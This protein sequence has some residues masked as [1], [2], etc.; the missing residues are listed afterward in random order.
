ME[1]SQE[2][3][4]TII[5]P[6]RANHGTFTLPEQKILSIRHG[7][8]AQ[9]SA[10][11]RRSQIYSSSDA[12]TEFS[13]TSFHGIVWTTVGAPKLGRCHWGGGK[14]SMSEDDR[15]RTLLPFIFC[16]YLVYMLCEGALSPCS[17]KWHSPDTGL[18]SPQN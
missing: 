18:P 13:R 14:C 3:F 11:L 12:S 16:T 10:E 7:N 4:E 9:Y 6:E 1:A 5:S 2:L 17:L 15:T 8:R